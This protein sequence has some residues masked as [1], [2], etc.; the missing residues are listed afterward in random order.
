MI[1]LSCHKLGQTTIELLSICLA[2]YGTPLYCTGWEPS[3]PY[4]PDL[5]TTH[6]P[7]RVVGLKAEG[8][9]FPLRRFWRIRK[10]AGYRTVIPCRCRPQEDAMSNVYQFDASQRKCPVGSLATHRDYGWCQI[11]SADGLLRGIEYET[12]EPEIS[13]EL[14]ELE[15]GILPEELLLSNR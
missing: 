5:S 15:D 14:G 8:R 12:R 6:A 1:E 11:I 13:P 4:L 10:I 3:L 7:H 9:L 2:K